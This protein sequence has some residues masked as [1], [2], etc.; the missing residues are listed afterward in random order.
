MK[1]VVVIGL[2]NPLMT[3]EGIGNRV[4]AEVAAAADRFPEAECLDLGTSGMAVLHALA[5]RRKAI[6]L[7]CAFMGE[8]PGTL[9]R[10]TPQEVRSG[11]LERGFT[12]HEGDLLQF[13]ELARA[14]S[15][16]PEEIVIFGIQ[17]EDVSPGEG[18]SATLAAR[19]GEY[20]EAVLREL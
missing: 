17:P 15:D 8:A 6:L 5:G 7:D 13:V 19:V 16:A 11:K 18:L 2:G 3:D 9:R 4:V 14:V 10:F 1:P 20:V 12:M